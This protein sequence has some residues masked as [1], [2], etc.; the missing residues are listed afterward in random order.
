MDM[1]SLMKQAQGMQSKMAAV[2]ASLKEKVVDGSAGDGL[3]TAY[4]NGEMDLLKVEIDPKVVDPDDVDMLEDLVL[5]AV[6]KAMEEMKTI[7]QAEMSKVT[8]GMNI[9]GMF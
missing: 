9:P 4:V 1:G 2:Q 8:G 5:A 6:N 3:V 7:S